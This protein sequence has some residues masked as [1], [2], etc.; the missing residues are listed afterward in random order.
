MGALSEKHAFLDLR[1]LA[2]KLL[3]ET[4]A[5]RRRLAV[6]LELDALQWLK[7]LCFIQHELF[8]CNRSR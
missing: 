8:E 6:A 2:H 4:P 3:P 1:D 5:Y 7:A